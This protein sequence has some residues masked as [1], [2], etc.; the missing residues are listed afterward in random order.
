MMERLNNSQSKLGLAQC[1]AFINIIKNLDNSNLA[2]ALSVSTGDGIWDYLV[3]DN[4][5]RVKKITATDIVDDPVDSKSKSL[6]KEKGQWQFVKVQPEARL[7]FNDEEFGLIFHQDVIEHVEKP[8]LFLKEQHRVL[9]NNGYLF[10]GTPNLFRFANVL[11]ILSGKLKFPVKVGSNSIIG[12]YIH[13]QEFHEQQMK[14]LLSEIGFKD[15]S[16]LYVYFGILPLNLTFS[17]FPKSIFGKTMCQYLMFQA[18][19]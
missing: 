16:V 19:K 12:D 2:N 8:Y 11:K 17:S 4:N 14:I 3:F 15:I 6:L 5:Q 13:I 7:P 1:K 18:T 10:F 9:K